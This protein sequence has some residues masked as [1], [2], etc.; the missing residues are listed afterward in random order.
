[1]FGTLVLG[2]LAGV[3]AFTGRLDAEIEELGPD[4]AHLLAHLRTDV[5]PGRLRAQA[6]GRGQGL[7][8]GD[9]GAEDEHLRGWHR[10][11]RGGEH[12]E[13]PRQFFGG[14][15]NRAITGDT[16]LRGQRVHRLRPRNPGN[17]FD[18]ERDDPGA[19][20]RGDAV[21]VAAGVEEA[22]EEGAGGEF[23]DLVLRR[24]GDL[25]DDVRAPRVTDTRPGPLENL[26]GQVRTLAGTGFDDDL[27]AA[28]G[29]ALD[30]FRNERHPAFSRPGF[31]DDADRELLGLGHCATSS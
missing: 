24:R 10:A 5:V 15:K 1:L 19:F 12:R 4:R 25:E 17:G 7:Q 28:L 8:P 27:Q 11:G 18:G 31:L 3:P 26:V 16:A 23:A 2:E 6:F 20:Q 13:E 9:T 29:E 22:D 14:Q 30:E 21:G